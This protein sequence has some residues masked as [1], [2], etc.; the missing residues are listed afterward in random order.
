MVNQGVF[1]TK[2]IG[3]TQFMQAGFTGNRFET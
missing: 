3:P 2:V 1:W